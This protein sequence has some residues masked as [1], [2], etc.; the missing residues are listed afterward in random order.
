MRSRVWL[1]S[2]L[3]DNELENY[4]VIIRSETKLL[5]KFYRPEAILR[6]SITVDDLIAI[7]CGQEKTLFSIHMDYICYRAREIFAGPGFNSPYSKLFDVKF[8][9]DESIRSRSC[10][11]FSVRSGRSFLNRTPEAQSYSPAI[12]Q[13]SPSIARFG[14]LLNLN[15]TVEFCTFTMRIMS[16]KMK[17]ITFL[18]FSAR[19]AFALSTQMMM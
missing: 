7:A 15:A 13:R 10:S 18:F 11:A 2:I 9:W 1:C 16:D 8:N 12:F 19:K 5:Q 6:D 17:V 4:L 14:K 3:N